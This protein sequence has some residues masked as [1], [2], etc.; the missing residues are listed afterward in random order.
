M[1]CSIMLLLLLLLLRLGCRCG[2]CVA[3]CNGSLLPWLPLPQRQETSSRHGRGAASGGEPP[4]RAG[5][6]GRC[7]EVVARSSTLVVRSTSAHNTIII[8]RRKLMLLL[9]TRRTVVAGSLTLLGDVSGVTESARS[10]LETQI[11]H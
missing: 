3:A 8:Y 10:R 4:E 7:S 9:S 5:H 1:L 2:C 6:A 11:S